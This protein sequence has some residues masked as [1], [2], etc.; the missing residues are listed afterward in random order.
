MAARVEAKIVVPT[1]GAAVSVSSGALTSAVTATLAAG[2]YYMTAAGG[3]SSLPTVL[4]STINAAVS[5]YPDNAASAAA[6]FGYGGWD[7]AWGFNI[8]SGND[9]GLFGG[10][11]LT[12]AGSPSYSNTGPGHGGDKAIGFTTVADVF[13]GGDVLDTTGTD[14]LAVA[15]VGYYSANGGVSRDL[16]SK[17]AAGAGWYIWTHGA[18]SQLRFTVDDGISVDIGTGGILTGEWHVGIAT[19][20]RA[21]GKGR[22]GIKGLTSGT[23]HVSAL[24]TLTTNTLANATALTAGAGAIGSADTTFK[25]AGLY[26]ATGASAAT[27]LAANLSTA[28]TSFASAVSSAFTVA[29]DTTST[30]RVTLANTFWPCSVAWTSTALRD[31]LGFEYDFQYPQTAAQLTTALGG[32]GTFTSGAG[33]LLNESSGNPAS[34]FGT[35]ASLTASSLTYSNLGARGGGDKAIGLDGAADYADGGDA[36]DIAASTDDIVIAWV[37]YQSADPSGTNGL[38]SK[39][40]AGGVSGWRIYTDANQTLVWQ[41]ITSGGVGAFTITTASIL[42]LRQ[43]YVGI[44][45]IDR[46]TGKARIGTCTMGGTVVVSTETTATAAAHSN[47]ATLRLG[48][49]TGELSAETSAL[50][51]AFYI[52][53]GASVA[54]GL[55]ANLSTALTSFAAY[56]KSQT[57]TEQAQFLWFPGS[58]LNVDDH[59]SMAPEETDLRTSESPTKFALGLSGNLGYAHTNARW[60]RVTVDRIREAEATYANASLEVFFRDAITGLGAHAWGGPCRDMQIIWSNQGTDAW[61]GADG[62]DGAGMAG[63]RLTGV[64]KF[65]DIAVPSQANWVGQWNVRFPRLVADD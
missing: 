31:A 58:P 27:G 53:T 39:Y 51:S 15:W 36:F 54:T 24:T 65:R 25:C 40:P 64:S 63:W 50:F 30:G 5:P 48:L 7:A 10:I 47:A 46:S 26:I 37:G 9:T 56:M 45:C 11:T 62:N 38:I 1:G 17:Y 42:P 8:A 23:S 61:L 21:T 19:I 52:A 57:G 18:G 4:T 59:P 32:Y 12:A 33:Y 41:A 3:V 34:V 60:E 49:I 2:D 35:P 20:D 22:I 16:F 55:S 44:A 43:W 13:S 14:D 28:L 6:M 29:L